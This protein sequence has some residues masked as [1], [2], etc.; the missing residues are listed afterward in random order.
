MLIKAAR[1]GAPFGLHGGL[2]LYPYSEQRDH[3]L[4]I[5][6]F[7]IEKNATNNRLN[8]SKISMHGDHL[9]VFFEGVTDRTAAEQW[10]GK[11]LFLSPEDLPPLPE[12][13]Y[14]WHQLQGLT[15]KSQTGQAL[16]TVSSLYSNGPQDI[17]VIDNGDQIPF[18]LGTTV[19]SVDLD[20]KIITVLFDDSSYD[21]SPE[22]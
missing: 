15:I 5:Q 10:V 22:N 7:Y 3:L 13:Q 19:A 9:R 6:C 21:D 20:K 18:I 14:Y 8:V 1:I 11:E 4:D 12:G 17:L 16:G 2:H